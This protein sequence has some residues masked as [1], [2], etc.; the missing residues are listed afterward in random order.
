M[1]IDTSIF[2]TQIPS[3]KLSIFQVQIEPLSHLSHESKY[4]SIAQACRVIYREEGLLGF[5]KGHNPAQVLSIG[6][7]ITQFTVYEFLTEK[8]A[9]SETLQRHTQLKS[10]VCG[11]AAGAAAS[12]VATPLDV[13]RTRIIVQDKHKGYRNS[14]QATK[15]IYAED[16]IRGFYRGFVPSLWQIIPLAGL[17][18]L[19]YNFYCTQLQQAMKLER[20]SDIPGWG[21][22]C[23]GALTGLSA[24]ST[25]YPL[26][27]IKKRL[28]IQGFDHH[29]RTYGQ[30]FKCNGVAHCFVETVK[31]EGVRGLYKGISASVVKAM[32]TTALNFGIYDEVKQLLLRL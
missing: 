11:G 13:I 18:F 25:V 21:L 1:F 29:H 2:P 32:V 23:M 9:Q 14:V 22:L 28:Q 12:V 30:H 16:G 4:K 10:F 31:R 19:F 8:S 26:D 3:L 15:L 5:W 17:N 6:Y 24:R 7:G 27:V 20:H